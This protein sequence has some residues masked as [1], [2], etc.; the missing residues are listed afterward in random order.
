MEVFNVNSDQSK[1]IDLLLAKISSLDDGLVAL[2]C[3]QLEETTH[4]Q[5]AVTMSP[6]RKLYAVLKPTKAENLRRIKAVLEFVGHEFYSCYRT[7]VLYWFP[8][9]EAMTE[10]VRLEKAGMLSR[11]QAK[12]QLMS[13]RESIRI[14]DV[15]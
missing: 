13:I 2:W 1:D 5:A 11:D 10:V 3:E 15:P 12:D 6:N 7:G 8:R 14:G 4:G 9:F